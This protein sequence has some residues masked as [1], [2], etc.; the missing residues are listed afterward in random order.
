MMGD[1]T[2]AG[3]GVIGIENIFKIFSG[4]LPDSGVSVSVKNVK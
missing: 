3:A 1:A 2:M 4:L